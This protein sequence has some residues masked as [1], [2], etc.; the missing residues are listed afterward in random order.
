MRLRTTR[1]TGPTPAER[2]RS[3][4]TVAHSMTVVADGRR[5][6][7]HSL[8]GTA[9]MGRIH[10]HEPSDDLGSDDLGSGD[11]TPRVPIRVEL[12]DIAPAP[13]RDRLRAR[14]TLTGLVAAPYL[15]ETAES[16]CVQLGQAVL[17]DAGGRT[18]VPLAQLETAETDP[19]AGCEASMLHHLTADHP[20]L[21]TRLLRLADPGLTHGL[22]R[23]LPLAID[24][25][26]ITLRLEHATTHH[27]VRL[28]FPTAIT[29]VDQ[30]GLQI[31]AVLTAARRAAH[32][33]LSA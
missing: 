27:D 33:H 9:A 3:I 25:Y 31:H 15:A 7:V 5:H 32:S 4:I 10:L 23:A 30:V 13:V 21:V 19:L 8:D 16:T 24:R 2:M 1:T 14:V 20:D 22:E 28:P 18:Y 11:R 12:T 26:G 6:E 29:E 17:E